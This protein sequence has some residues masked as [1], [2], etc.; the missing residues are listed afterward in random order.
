MSS[1]AISLIKKNM[2]VKSMYFV[3]QK[4]SERTKRKKQLIGKKRRER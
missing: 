3:Q 1:V 2:M 4:G